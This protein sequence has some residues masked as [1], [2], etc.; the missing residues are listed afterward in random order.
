MKYEEEPT[1]LL[2]MPTDRKVFYTDWDKEVIRSLIESERGA[3]LSDP[4][5][6]RILSE[7]IGAYLSGDRS[8][9]DTAKILQSRVNTYLAE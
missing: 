7:E 9:A 4:T 1:E 2:I 6:D 8:A 5:L 3:V